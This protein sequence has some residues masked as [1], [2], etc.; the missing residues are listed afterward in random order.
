M[1]A[2][3][4]RTYAEYFQSLNPFKST[5]PAPAPASP[6][7]GDLPYGGKRKGRKGSKKTRRIRRRR[8]GTRSTRS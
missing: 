5:A 3:P 6:P 7:A 4:Q 1:E 8:N 2:Q